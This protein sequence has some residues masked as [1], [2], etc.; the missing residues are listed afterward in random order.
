M[1]VR[2]RVCVCVCNLCVI[3][4]G[5]GKIRYN[6]T[7]IP[8]RSKGMVWCT[9]YLFRASTI[10][11]RNW[12][13]VLCG[14]RFF[15][16]VA[17]KGLYKTVCPSVGSSV[18]PSVCNAFTFR[19]SRGDICRVYGLAISLIF[20]LVATKRLYMPESR[21]VDGLSAYQERRCHACIAL[22]MAKKKSY[23]LTKFTH[24]NWDKLS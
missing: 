20:F 23:K 18:H 6:S 1:C 16:L 19:P 17:T 8:L 4:F 2:V 9:M 21:S 24:A 13:D 11:L 5:G 22:A 15:F 12:T 10:R 7:N 14:S 3:S